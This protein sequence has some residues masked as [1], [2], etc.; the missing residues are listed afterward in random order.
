M[1][2]PEGSVRSD[3]GAVAELMWATMATTSGT[4]YVGDLVISDETDRFRRLVEAPAR[5]I[6]ESTSLAEQLNENRRRQR[7]WNT[8]L[9]DWV[10]SPADFLYNREIQSAL[11][12][13]ATERAPD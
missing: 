12:W 3:D 1:T 4:A 13:L 5:P 9:P 7:P 10:S 11:A 2:D 6:P 8:D